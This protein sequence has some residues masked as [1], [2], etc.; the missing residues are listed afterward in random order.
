M[1]RARQTGAAGL[2]WLVLLALAA[3]LVWTLWPRSAAQTRVS[4]ASQTSLAPDLASLS[5]KLIPQDDL[6]PAGTRSLFDHLVA[7]N[8][9]LPYPFG[10]LV[11][12]VQKQDPAV[13]PPLVLM[14]PKGR[15]LLKAMADYEYPRVLYAADFQAPDRTALGLAPRSR[16]FLGFVENA[17]EV[18][19]ISYNEAAGRYEFQLIQ[20]YCEGCQPRLV[21][22][23]RAVCM[24]CHQGAVPIF[25]VRPWDETNGETATAKAIADA[26]RE[27][28]LDPDHYLGFPI[29]N[30]LSAPERFQDLVDTGEFLAVTQRAWLDGCAGGERGTDCRRQ[31]LKVAVD[32]LWAPGQFDAQGA[33]A[34]QLR[35]L[36]APAWPAQ[37]IA[38]PGNNILNRDPIG[39]LQGVRGF[40]RRLTEPKVK[41]GTG[42]RNNEDLASLDKLP[43]L[44]EALDPLSQRDPKRVLAADDLDG[45]FGLAGMLTGSD[46]ERLEQAAGF[47]LPRLRDA[48]EKIPADFFAPAPIGRV[49]IMRAML[50]AL[51]APVPEYCCLDT[52]DMSP[53]LSSGE[54]PV[55]IA[56][57]SPV[58]N[59]EHYCF[60]CHRGN[61][62]ARLNFMSGKTEAEVLAHIKA[63]SEISDVLDWPRYQGTDKA[64]KMM[65][66]ADSAQRQM[67]QQDLAKNPKLL[68]DMRGVVPSLFS[69]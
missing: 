29:S 51:G 43:K 2:W 54:P 55:K 69:F 3:A 41:P 17:H 26:R 16:L 22:I 44:P 27:A 46:F 60:A 18:E 64:N 19:V 11:E 66:P 45:G 21:Y 34:V 1:K 52:K 6:P 38:I 7:Q 32:Y 4:A 31:M 10:K 42:P 30:P 33:D 23:K 67:L 24:A 53:P 13:T 59:F 61:P 63:K 50:A 40:F 5:Y 36:Q 39:E 56:A 14:I 68:D 49:R 9:S 12:M 28:K 8:E 15:S 57:N 58:R 65:P 48:V 62:N 20:N 25:P 35:Q 47:Q 37:G